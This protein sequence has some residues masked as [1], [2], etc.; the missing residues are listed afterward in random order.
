[1]ARS[2]SPSG[3]PAS[4][5]IGTSQPRACRS[6]GVA[7]RRTVALKRR[8][9][10]SFCGGRAKDGLPKPFGLSYLSVTNVDVAYRELVPAVRS[11][12]SPPRALRGYG[13]ELAPTAT[14]L[15]T[16]TRH[17]CGEGQL[18][19]ER[20]VRNAPQGLAGPFPPLASH[21]FSVS[22][23][24]GE[25][26]SDALRYCRSGGRSRVGD[27][28]ARRPVV[29]RVDDG[30]D[31]T[32]DSSSSTSAPTPGRVRSRPPSPTTRA[33]ASGT[34][35]R[36]HS[37]R[38]P[39]LAA[40]RMRDGSRPRRRSVAD[41]RSGAVG[42]MRATRPARP[43]SRR[44]S[45]RRRGSGMTEFCE[46]ALDDDGLRA[47]GCGRRERP[48]R[49]RTPSHRWP[50]PRRADGRQL[51]SGSDDRPHTRGG[52]GVFSRL[53]SSRRGARSSSICRHRSS[54]RS[55]RVVARL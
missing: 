25:R 26:G 40:L 23:P 1:M 12:T 10:P 50:G 2:A 36:T 42:A 29:L 30:N 5:A 14:A 55:G 15:E 19:A 52:A 44:R 49:D 9:L 38:R 33:V 54:L 39:R 47:A 37:S 16:R 48:R 27:P 6:S 11:R 13:G 28:A 22:Q 46:G 43:P 4:R 24:D 18:V 17:R 31:S 20:G 32:V 51:S 41:A 35:R 3:L 8:R 45:A 34:P 53:V 7:D 21:R